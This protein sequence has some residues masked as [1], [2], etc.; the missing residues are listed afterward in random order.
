MNIEGVVNHPRQLFLPDVN[1]QPLPVVVSASRRT[2]L[3][4]LKPGWLVNALQRFPA[5]FKR[6]IHSVVLWTK[7]PRNVYKNE[8]LRAELSKYNLLVH[9]TITGLGGTRI[10]PTVP[11]ADE[12]IRELPKLLDFLGN[13]KRFRWRFDPIVTLEKE[14]GSMWSSV[15]YS[16]NLAQQMAELGIDNCYFSFCQ[17]YSR[18]FTNRSLKEAGITF[19]TPS[20]R[21]QR[22]IVGK[23]KEIAKPLGITL[24]PCTQPQLEGVSGTTPASCIDAALLTQLHPKR[25]PA[26]SKQDPTMVRLRPGCYCTESIDIGAYLP[27]G[28][29]CVYCYA[30]AAVPKPDKL[31]QKPMP[32][33]FNP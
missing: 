2:E 27:C 33:E 18:K 22:D 9:C 3:V 30:E 15:A 5:R 11:R 26:S 19:I 8:A 25:L 23:M 24:Y 17:I 12:L 14:D 20:L 29:G 6:D 28:H 31:F 10:E 16:E 1:F 13:P 4:G 32:W 21:E 7:D